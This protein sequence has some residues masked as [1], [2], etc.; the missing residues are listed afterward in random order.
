MLWQQIKHDETVQ[1]ALDA[2]QTQIRELR[3]RESCLTNITTK[4]FM[5]YDEPDGIMTV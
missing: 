4:S 1:L 5:C 3:F 2:S